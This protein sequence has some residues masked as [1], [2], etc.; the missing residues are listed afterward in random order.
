[1]N[2]K[3]IL[4]TADSIIKRQDFDRVL[5]LFFLNMTIKDVV[6]EK[7]LPIFDTLISASYDVYGQI[8]ME[9]ISLKK[10]INVEWINE[11]GERKFLQ[12]IKDYRAARYNIDFTDTGEPTYYVTIGN[13]MKILP[14]PE[15]GTIDIYGEFYP[16]DLT[17]SISSTNSM[18]KEVGNALVYLVVGEYFDMLQEENRGKYWKQKGAILIDKYS[19]FIHDRQTQGVNMMNRNPFGN[20]TYDQDGLYSTDGDDYDMG[21][22]N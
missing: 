2:A 19:M 18:T 21:T 20:I 1:M 6:R 4:D 17:D 12:R 22:F 14:V 16:S 3:E 13:T 15:D 9:S 5:G 7:R 10:A 8:D 11:D